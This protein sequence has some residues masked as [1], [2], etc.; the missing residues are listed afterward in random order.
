MEKYEIYLPLKYND[1]NDIEP[2]KL[3]EIQQQ[4]IA[5]FWRNDCQFTLGSISRNMALRR[6]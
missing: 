6:C 4:L 5:V 3:E 2:K 1:G